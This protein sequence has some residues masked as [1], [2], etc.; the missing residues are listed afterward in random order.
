MIGSAN[1]E[2]ATLRAA[3]AQAYGECQRMFKCSNVLNRL[4]PHAIPSRS[5]VHLL[6]SYIYFFLLYNTTHL[7]PGREW[8]GGT[9]S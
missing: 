9:E 1:P 6:L 7:R 3:S 5:K 2:G 4:Y 8:V